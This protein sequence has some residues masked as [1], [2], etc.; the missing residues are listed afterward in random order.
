MR[1]VWPR[2]CLSRSLLAVLALLLG[3]AVLATR[4]RAA[5]LV[6]FVEAGCPWCARWDSE[7][8]EA[9]ANSE[10]GRIAP[11]RRVEISAARMSGIRLARAV[12]V[13]PTFVLVEGG[14]EV[15]RITGYPGADFFW[16]MLGELMARL[17]PQEP[18][19]PGEQRSVSGRQTCLPYLTRG[20]AWRRV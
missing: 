11:L 17:P 8:S 12:T 3:T 15:G 14:A 16:G 13:T 10:E 5:E 18:G 9:Y 19:S 2:R 1:V 4:T 20:V 7:V 6:M